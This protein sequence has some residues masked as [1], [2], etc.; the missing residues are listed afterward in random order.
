MASSDRDKNKAGHQ[1]EDP[2]GP[3]RPRW[4]EP[5]PKAPIAIALD[6]KR[7]G[8]VAA[9]ASI[10]RDRQSLLAEVEMERVVA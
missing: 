4:G 7:N 10:F 9:V 3:P 6:Y 8:R 1:P 2:I 5:K